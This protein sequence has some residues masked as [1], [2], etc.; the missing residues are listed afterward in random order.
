[1]IFSLTARIL[2][3]TLPSSGKQTDPAEFAACFAETKRLSLF[4]K[5]DFKQRKEE[6]A[7]PN[8]IRPCLGIDIFCGLSLRFTE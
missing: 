5:L 2:C 6:C 1:M 4:P 3:E 8:Y 7:V